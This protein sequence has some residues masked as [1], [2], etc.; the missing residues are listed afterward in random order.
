VIDFSFIRDP[1]SPERVRYMR[2]RNA[3]GQRVGQFPQRVRL[4]GASCAPVPFTSELDMPALAV[5]ARGLMTPTRLISVPLAA[6][7]PADPSSSAVRHDFTVGEG[8]A[9]AVYVVADTEADDVVGLYLM[10]DGN[11]DGR[12][13]FADGELAAEGLGG[14]GLSL[15]YAP[16]PLPAGR[17]QLWVHGVVVNGDASV[18][19]LDVTVFQ[20]THLRLEDAPT[21]LRD[22]ETGELRVCADDVEALDGPRMGAIEFAYDSPPR[23]FRVMVDWTPAAAPARWTVLLPLTLADQPLP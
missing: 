21:S 3:V 20:G 1:A 8:G 4:E 12:F 2:N 5:H 11:D 22:G 9:D 19:D 14:P 7:D 17:Y 23:L 16:D 18:L 6:D 10:R 13:T 15:L